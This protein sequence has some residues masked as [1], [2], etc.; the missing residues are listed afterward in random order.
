MLKWFAFKR[1]WDEIRDDGININKSV[2]SIAVLLIAVLALTAWD[3]H[4]DHKE[5]TP[6]DEFGNPFYDVN[7]EII[8][9]TVPEPVTP[10]RTGVDGEPIEG[11]FGYNYT[12]RFYPREYI[13]IPLRDE[14]GELITDENGN[15]KTSEY[16]VMWH[17]DPRAGG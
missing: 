7:G 4:D 14:N 3:F 9:V 2:V 5:Y 15:V 6:T 1:I 13:T 16:V 12:D 11:P 17:Y 8:T 10:Y